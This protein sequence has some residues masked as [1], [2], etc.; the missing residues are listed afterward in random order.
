ML[1]ESAPGP[2][3]YLAVAVAS[4]RCPFSA[5]KRGD[6]TPDRAQRKVNDRQGGL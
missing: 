2:A 1:I 4:I 6:L 3:P 5:A